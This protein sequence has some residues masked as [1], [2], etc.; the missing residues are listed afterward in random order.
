M[1]VLHIWWHEFEVPKP[2][3]GY[4]VDVVPRAWLRMV[5]EDSMD[6]WTPGVS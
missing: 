1:D 5:P 4:N 3:R 2:Y 6:I